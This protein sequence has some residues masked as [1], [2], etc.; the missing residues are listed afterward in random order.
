[1]EDG[2]H[3][4]VAAEHP[5]RRD[6]EVK[7]WGLLL[8]GEL[9]TYVL[10]AGESMTMKRYAWLVEH[11]FAEWVTDAW[12]T[13]GHAFLVQD[14]E[15]CLWGARPKEA[16]R[17]EDIRLLENF[18][19]SSQDLNAIET[20]WREVRGRLDATQPRGLESRAAFLQRLRRAVAWVNVHRATYLRALC[21]SQKERARGPDSEGG[22]DG[23]VRGARG[24]EHQRLKEGVGDACP[25]RGHQRLKEGACEACL[26]SECAPWTEKGREWKGNGGE[27]A[28]KK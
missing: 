24:T 9:R 8:N 2:R 26:A 23:M 14:H 20:A 10:P 18:P 22:K 28:R 5:Q 3:P 4:P 21:E 12:G 17:A 19:R 11:K 25:G 13:E 1:M 15:R 7:I 16:L 6:G 27:E